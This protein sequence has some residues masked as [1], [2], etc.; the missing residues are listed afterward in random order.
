[1]V[2]LILQQGF[3]ADLVHQF[4]KYTINNNILNYKYI[5]KGCWICNWSCWRCLCSCK[6]SLRKDIRWDDFNTYFCR[7][8]GIVWIDYCFNI[9]AVKYIKFYIHFF[10]F[11]KESFFFK[12]QFHFIRICIYIIFHQFHLIKLF[13]KMLSSYF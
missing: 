5:F 4:N 9:I 13:S 2:I 3:V 10:F 1:M 7:S 6:C 11:Q 12:F 8:I